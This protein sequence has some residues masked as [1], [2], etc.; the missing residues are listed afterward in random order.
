MDLL[1]VNRNNFMP[2]E[3]L[4]DYH[5]LIWTERYR[6]PGDFE[7]KTGN[8]GRWMKLLPAMSLLT[9]RDTR[10]VMY[11]ET[12][13]IGKDANGHAE[14]TIKG[15]SL[16]AFLQN[17]HLQGPYPKLKYRMAKDYTAAAAAIVLVWNAVVNSTDKDVTRPGPWNRSVRDRV[18]D[19]VV[20]DS[21][22]IPGRHKN[23][24]LSSG[25]V[26]PQLMNYLIQDQLGI[27][28]IR[29]TTSGKIATVQTNDSGTIQYNQNGSINH[30]RWDI[31]NGKDRRISQPE[32]VEV[33]FHYDSGHLTDA[34]YLYS[35]DKFKTMAFVDSSAG[36]KKYSRGPGQEDLEGLDRRTIW[37]DGGQVSLESTSHDYEDYKEY[38]PRDRRSP[39]PPDLTQAMIDEN[40]EDIEEQNDDIREENQEIRQRNNALREENESVKSRNASSRAEFLEDLAEIGEVSLAENERIEL[41]DG[42]VTEDIPYKY[43]R[44]YFLGDKVTVL[45]EYD[46]QQSMRVNEYI[47]TSDDEGDHGYPGLA[48]IDNE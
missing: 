25:E 12:R 23:R 8:V 36:T 37:V 47:R 15:R 4:E 21:T 33:V 48:V 42:K 18:P 3:L 1:R 30:L 27:R 11:V 16:D 10:E 38:I 9:L 7:I 45:A 32:N 40:N 46:F 6:D 35:I 2:D 22:T 26:Y 39:N 24:W 43:G 14:L 34:T 31:Y 41:F 29:P 5:S 13:S 28:M 19:S 20:T 17:R 44:D